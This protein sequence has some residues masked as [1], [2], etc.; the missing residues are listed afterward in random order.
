MTLSRPTR[1]FVML[2]LAIAVA[3]C[4][5]TGGRKKGGGY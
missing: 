2:L 1:L 5:S 4:S 3:G